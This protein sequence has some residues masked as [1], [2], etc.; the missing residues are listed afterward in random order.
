LPVDD[1]DLSTSYISQD[2]LDVDEDDGTRV[3]ITCDEG[4]YALHQFKDFAGNN[5]ACTLTWDGQ[6]NLAPSISTV[7][8]QIY[9]YDTPGWETVDSDDATAADT[10][11]VLTANIADLTNYKSDGIMTCRVYQ[12]G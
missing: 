5:D 8:L 2:Y 9:N 4:D 12:R 1:S 11:F 3:S 7:Y 10:D 6:S